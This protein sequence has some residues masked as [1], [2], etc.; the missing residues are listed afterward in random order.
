MR[1]LTEQDFERRYDIVA[2]RSSRPVATATTVE[3][4]SEDRETLENTSLDLAAPLLEELALAIDPYPKMPGA[5][6]EGGTRENS[7][8]ESPFAVLRTLK[9][10]MEPPEKT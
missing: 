5:R 8:S 1:T 9:D 4:E 7:S 6:F 3:L 2:P 10:K